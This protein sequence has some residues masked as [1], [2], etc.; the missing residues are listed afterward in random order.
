MHPSQE[1]ASIVRASWSF[2]QSAAPTL[3]MSR[4]GRSG[5]A[6]NPARLPSAATPAS[7]SPA[8]A[9]LVVDAPPELVWR[10]VAGLGEWSSWYPGFSIVELGE[11]AR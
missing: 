9:S 7:N 1:K 10:V 5:G 6:G 4:P 2:R 8:V 3:P 11:V